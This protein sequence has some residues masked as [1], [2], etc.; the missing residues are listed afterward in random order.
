MSP[1]PTT[2]IQHHFH[3]NWCWKPWVISFRQS[4]ICLAIY[5][6]FLWHKK[7][8][9]LL[10]STHTHTYTP[11]TVNCILHTNTFTIIPSIHSQHVKKILRAKSILCSVSKAKK[12]NAYDLC[13]CI[14]KCGAFVCTHVHIIFGSFET[15]SI[16]S[17]E[18]IDCK[19][20]YECVFAMRA[21]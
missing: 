18:H 6:Q 20:V 21:N 16:P 19:C 7:N 12:Q 14:W 2:E 1:R 17:N 4:L 5:I 9:Q 13:V 3:Q 11:F 8:N 15:N 10:L